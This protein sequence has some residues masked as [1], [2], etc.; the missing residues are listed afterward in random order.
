MGGWGRGLIV[1]AIVLTGAGCTGPVKSELS[2]EDAAASIAIDENTSLTIQPTVLG[3]GEAFLSWFGQQPGWTMDIDSY[4][5][6]RSVLFSWQ[7]GNELSAT[8]GTYTFAGLEGGETMLIPKFWTPGDI[9]HDDKTGIW[10]SRLQY[11]ELK[12]NGSTRISLGL[13][14][15]KLSSALQLKDDVSNAL[16]ALQQKTQDAHEGD[17]IVTVR[18]KDPGTY[19]LMIDDV[20]TT[21]ATLE[22][23]NWFAHYTVLDNPEHPIV[24]KLIVSPVASAGTENFSWSS[25]L[26]SFIGYAVTDIQHVPNE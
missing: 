21:V 1:A 4:A 15:E 5:A 17:D 10:L 24:L 3:L 22:A 11:D 9:A 13:F 14:D 8:V 23:E 26:K 2:P 18:A 25:V 6:N 12:A 16:A 20:Q 7:T 19:T